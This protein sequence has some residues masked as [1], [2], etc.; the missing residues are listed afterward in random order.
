[1]RA[2]SCAGSLAKWSECW[3]DG[4]ATGKR[5]YWIKLTKEFM[6]EDIDF[7]MNQKNGAQYVVLYQM[8]CFATINTNGSCAY[9]VG[10]MIVPYDVDKIRRECKYF[11]NDTIIVALELFKKLGWVYEQEN[12]VLQIADFDKKVGSE[13]DWAVK[14]Q[15]QRLGQGGDNVPELSPPMSPEMSPQS[16]SKSKRQSKETELKTDTVIQQQ[17]VNG[18]GAR[19]EKGDPPSLLEVTRYMKTE[20]DMINTAAEA[21]KFIAWNA[22]RGWVCLPNW[23]AA[24]D[25]WCARIGERG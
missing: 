3:G 25:L 4:M 1:M 13:T 17:L 21:E 18:A 10:E 22:V 16:K 2:R 7:L 14:K 8:L 19:E 9:A 24:A 15:R 23:Q 6:L 20:F 12:G 11:D 5:F